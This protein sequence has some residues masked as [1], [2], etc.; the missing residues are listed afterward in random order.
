M[1]TQ[2]AARKGHARASKAY[3]L[4]LANSWPPSKVLYK[5][6]HYYLAQCTLVIHSATHNWYVE[7]LQLVSDT[8]PLVKNASC[9]EKLS[10]GM[11]GIL[12]HHG[13]QLEPRAIALKQCCCHALAQQRTARTDDRLAK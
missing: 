8:L 9:V 4:L 12:H 6:S 2:A 3:H 1:H 13:S 7:R 5:L 10:V 11:V